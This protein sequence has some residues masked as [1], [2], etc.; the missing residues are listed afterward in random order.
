MRGLTLLVKLAPR[1]HEPIAPWALAAR[2]LTDALRLSIALASPVIVAA[3]ALEVALAAMARAAAPV[4]PQPIAY[5]ARPL[6]ALVAL[7]ASL[8]VAMRIVR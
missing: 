4:S 1:E 2:T 5:V 3:L 6:V 7:A 8:D